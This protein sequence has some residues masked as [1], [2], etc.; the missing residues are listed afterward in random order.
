MESNRQQQ[1][2]PDE[3]K[4]RG[5]ERAGKQIQEAREVLERFDVAEALLRNSLDWSEVSEH[6][7]PPEVEAELQALGYIEQESP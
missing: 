3:R 2:D 7:L 6:E 5:P 1:L 4:G